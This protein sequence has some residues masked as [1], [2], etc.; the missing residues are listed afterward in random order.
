MGRPDK[1]AVSI[2]AL[3]GMAIKKSPAPDGMQEIFYVV[4]SVQRISN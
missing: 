1:R 3:P 2:A 4:R